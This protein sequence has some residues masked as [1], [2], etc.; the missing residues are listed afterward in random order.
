MEAA[1]KKECVHV[2]EAVLTTSEAAEVAFT[3]PHG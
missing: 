2:C 3:L 1:E